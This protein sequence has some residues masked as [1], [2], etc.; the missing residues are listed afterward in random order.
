M[1]AWARAGVF[2]ENETPSVV[3]SV[4]QQRILSL[5]VQFMAPASLRLLDTGWVL[6]CWPRNMLD[7]GPQHKPSSEANLQHSDGV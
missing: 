6:S 3:V 7:S 4:F 5:S 1:K 2:F